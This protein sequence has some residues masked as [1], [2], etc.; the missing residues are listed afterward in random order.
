MT[1][2]QENRQSDAEQH[3]TDFSNVNEVQA[4]LDEVQAPLA[5]S[6]E[7]LHGKEEVFGSTPEGGSAIMI[8]S[9]GECASADRVDSSIGRRGGVAQMVRALDS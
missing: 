6:V 2:R 1:I 3:I 4:N 8:A 5:Q 9:V 7:R